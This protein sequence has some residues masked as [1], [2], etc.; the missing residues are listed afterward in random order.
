[1]G[2]KKG[3]KWGKREKGAGK[4]AHA[5]SGFTGSSDGRTEKQDDEKKTEKVP[6][7]KKSVRTSPSEGIR[8]I[9]HF[10]TPAKEHDKK[11]HNLKNGTKRHLKKNTKSIKTQTD[12]R[13]QKT[14][15][16]KQASECHGQ[17]PRKK[18]RNKIELKFTGTREEI[19]KKTPKII[20]Q[21]TRDRSQG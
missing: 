7:S 9:S 20:G 5:K 11:R 17:K 21:T 18:P 8:K 6:S 19:R 14:N 10:T 1:M 16:Q 3:W 12:G 2:R 15:L 4:P 13:Q